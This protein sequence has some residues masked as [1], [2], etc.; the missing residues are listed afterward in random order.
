MAELPA[1][2][3]LR[4]GV[5]LFVKDPKAV[6]AGWRAVPIQ[7]DPIDGDGHLAFFKG[8]AG[9]LQK[10]IAP[11]DYVTF[12]V[13]DFGGRFL[14][15]LD[16]LPCRGASVYEIQD[17][18]RNRYAYLTSCGAGPLAMAPA[19]TFDEKVSLLE[20]PVYQYRFNPQNYMQFES[21]SFKGARGLWDLVAAD[22]RMLIRADVKKFF[23]M[24]FDSRHIESHLEDS[25][26]G[27]VG[28]L[29]RLTFFLRILFFHIDLSLSTDVGFYADAGH[30][31]MQ[32]NIPVN[33][34]D[35]LNAGSGILYSW[36]LT[37]VGQKGRREVR[38]PKLDPDLVKKGYSQLAKA[39]LTACNHTDCQYRYTV[40][41]RGRRLSMDLGVQRQLVERGFFPMYVED[42]AQAKQAMG[43]DI[44]L[45]NGVKRTGFYFEVSG[46]PEGGHPWDF[47]L[48]LGDPGESARLCPAPIRFAAVA[49]AALK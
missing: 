10:P 16:R 20:S 22:S 45:S 35:Y 32:V 36:T 34:F 8:D 31:P 42:V 41:V 7:V 1:L 26:L 6:G 49:P 37:S 14:P 21:I 3:G 25:R 19:V 33:S 12:R 46:L 23:T 38:M 28:D 47:W 4:Q 39:G 48:R 2:R 13:E 29:A 18:A 27:P 30:I 9:Y 24:S 17:P 44:D 15:H 40:D 43:W 5:R 11:Q